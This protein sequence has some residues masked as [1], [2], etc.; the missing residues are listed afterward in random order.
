[1]R[2]PQPTAVKEK[3]QSNRLL[4]LIRARTP[5][6]YLGSIELQRAQEEIARAAA[7]AKA[8]VWTYS[9]AQYTLEANQK[10]QTLDPLEVLTTIMK[11][12]NDGLM[13]SKQVVWVLSF[14]HF[15]LRKPLDMLIISRLREIIENS[16]FVDTVIILGRPGQEIPP[17]LSDIPVLNLG[18]F[19]RFHLEKSLN[20]SP[21]EFERI[22]RSS[23][24][25]TTRETENL[26]GMTMAQTGRLD[27]DCFEGLRMEYLESKGDGLLTLVKPQVS[28]EDIGGMELLKKWLM[29][30]G[31]AFRHPELVSQKG[32]PLPKGVLLTGIP[33]CG[34]SLLC[35]ALARDW[36]L[37]LFRLNPSKLYGP[38][39]GESEGLIRKA[40]GLIKKSAPVILWIDEIE[41]GF[42]RTDPRTDG[43]V[44]ARILGSFLHFLESRDAPVFVVATANDPTALPPEF[45]RKGRWD[46]VFFIDLPNE[47][48]REAIWGITLERMNQPLPIQREW[49][50]LCR[51]YS[52]AEICS[53]LED[54]AFECLYREVPLNSL[55]ISR[56]L[57]ATRPLSRLLPEKIAEL[58]Q[59]GL[60][61]ARPAGLSNSRFDRPTTCPVSVFQG[62][63]G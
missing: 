41:K 12:G 14:F 30:R 16:R 55:A 25:L 19:D 24:G 43:G 57:K 2:R 42:A 61:Q 35:Q 60:F 26:L 8:Q 1:M 33:G 47:S 17:E 38:G 54:A 44:S 53:V 32:L 49:I 5:L 28:L 3:D 56:A 58:R 21:E 36:D 39:L 20:L 7:Q 15:L 27:P 59:W 51:G 10:R 9:L 46:E 40:L 50:E 22:V 45:I 37:P 23:T 6:F 4:D 52:G 31:Y 29:V 11:R 18:G 48:E 13:Q 63:E 34:K 62:L